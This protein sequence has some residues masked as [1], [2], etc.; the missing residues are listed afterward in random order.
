MSIRIV[1]LEDPLEL[2]ELSLHGHRLAYRQA[3]KG[4][5]VVLIH[6]ITS[7]SRTWRRV[8]PYLARRF[9]VIA[10]DL[11]GH[12][13]SDKPKGDYSLGAHASAV[14]D[15]LVALG[16]DRASFVG[17]SLGG[18]IA[19]QLSY[20][21][22]ERCERLALVDSGGLGRGVSMLLRAA[23]LPG[24]ELV[25]PVLAASRMLDAGRLAGGLLRR[26]GLR[27]GTDI[28]EI[29]RGHATLADREARAAFVQTLR[30]VVEPGGQ[31][32]NAA[33]RLY[34][35]EQIPLLLIWGQHDSLIPVAHAHETH[36]L[37]PAS[38]L[39]VF[40]DSGHFPQLDQPERFIDV[41]AAF[42]D[43]TEPAKLDAEGWRELLKTG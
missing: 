8:L 25:L 32:V 27:A 10:P 41:L 12:G 16:H 9:T 22:P 24:S 37:L 36:E 13:G 6:G 4:P 34:L 39:E 31:R 28:E 42:I 43:S 11:I 7:D 2:R 15:L 38:Q 40:S 1:P 19:M 26:L 23:T 3:G 33:N 14:R 21:F 5:V 30:S 35:A 29:A 17:H 20:Q 18:G